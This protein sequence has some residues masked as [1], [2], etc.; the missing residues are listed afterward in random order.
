MTRFFAIAASVLLA[1]SAAVPVWASDITVTAEG[2]ARGMP[3]MANATF[4]ISTYAATAAV[5]VSN[6][7]VR[8]ERLAK[9]LNAL[10]IAQDDVQTTSF[11][12]SYNPPPR[13]PE[14]PQQGVRY[15]YFVSRSVNVTVHAVSA[16]GTV[17]DAAVD[18]GV[19][20]VNGVSFAIGDSSAQFALALRDAVRSARASAQALAQASGLRI[21]RVKEIREGAPTQILPSV[22]ADLYR[23]APAA[24]P[25][26]I[27]PSPVQ[28]SAT[29]TVIFDAQ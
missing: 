11:N 7:N 23:A 16:V 14:T 20:D 4:G 22:S 12:I 3:D 2:H 24:A 9:A 1:L 29:V 17:V 10:G 6:N 8:Y 18:A 19:T 21:V 27:P 13:P 5:A 26:Q 25:T 28:T 15:G